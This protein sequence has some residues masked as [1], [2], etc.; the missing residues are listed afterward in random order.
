MWIVMRDVRGFII[1]VAC[2]CGSLSRRKLEFLCK[3]SGR[4]LGEKL[5]SNF[6]LRYM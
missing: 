3:L 2:V 1:C 4:Y 5:G 6:L